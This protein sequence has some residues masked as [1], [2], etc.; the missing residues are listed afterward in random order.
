MNFYEFLSTSQNNRDKLGDSPSTSKRK[1]RKQ[2]KLNQKIQNTL[3]FN[4]MSTPPP[5]KK[6]TTT[7]PPFGESP[8]AASIAD[9]GSGGGGLGSL[10]GLPSLDRGAFNA[11]RLPTPPGRGSWTIELLVPGWWVGWFAAE[12]SFS[13]FLTHKCLHLGGGL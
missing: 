7:S 10:G 8:Q 9:A 1:K 5:K 6:I 11:S 13:S 3:V 4:S 2:K 12:F